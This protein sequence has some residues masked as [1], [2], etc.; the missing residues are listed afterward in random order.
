VGGRPVFSP[1]RGPLPPV[2]AVTNDAVLADPEF[3]SRALALLEAGGKDAA[4]HLRGPGTAVR[5]LLELHDILAPAARLNGSCLLV[6][7]R[8]D[9][10]RI[11]GAH[12]VHLGARSLPLAEARAILGPN[13]VIGVSVHSREEAR[14]IDGSPT[15]PEIRSDDPVRGAADFLLAGAVYAT[16]THPGRRPLGIGAVAEVAGESSLPVIVIG[17]VRL[18]SLPSLRPTGVRGVAAIRAIWGEPN[19]SMAFVRFVEVWKR[20]GDGRA[21]PGGADG[22]P[23]RPLGAE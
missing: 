6:N 10:A 20:S 4:L 3:V 18:E 16:E 12:G 8:V 15:V 2:H 21:E 5:R 11:V 9:L 13:V 23:P 22:V 19:P 17:G 14:K 1:T 7:D